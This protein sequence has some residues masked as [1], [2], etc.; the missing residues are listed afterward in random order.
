[1]QIIE[2]KIEK[3]KGKSFLYL[4]NKEKRIMVSKFFTS[5][6]RFRISNFIFDHQL[7]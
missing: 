2:K 7:F 3:K 1:M 5:I 6:R 4:K